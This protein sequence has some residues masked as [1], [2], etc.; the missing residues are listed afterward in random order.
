MPIAILAAKRAATRGH[1]VV[2]AT[3]VETTDDLLAE[4]AAA[5]GI[6]VERGPLADVLARF[7]HAL[8]SSPDDRIVVRLTG[9]NILPDGDLIAEVIEDF[10]VSDATYLST[11]DTKSGL[12][13]GVSVEVMRAGD[14]R[15]ANRLAS[16]EFEREHVTPWVRSNGK[17]AIFDRY[18]SLK[19]SEYRAT[20]DCFDDLMSMQRVFPKGRDP[21]HVPWREGVE[22]LPLGLYQPG[23]SVTRGDLVLGTAQLGMDYGINR[24]GSPKGSEAM[25][26][27]RQA[28][29]GGVQ[30][31]DTA[32]AYGDSE[33]VIGTIVKAGW[34]GRF[35]VVTK[36]DPL[37]S[38]KLDDDPKG[39]IAATRLSLMTSFHYLGLSRI[40]TVMLHRWRHW[41]AWGGVMAD[42]L[43]A[44]KTNGRIIK[45][46][47]SVQSPEELA[48]A[49][50]VPDI[51]HVQVPLNILDPRWDHLADRVDAARRNRGLVVHARS[52][53]LQGLLLSGNPDHWSH[54]HVVNRLPVVGWLRNLAEKYCGSAS[55]DDVL[56]LCLGW[57][58]SVPWVDGVV[59]GMDNLAQ[60]QTNLTIFSGPDLQPTAIREIEATRPILP[61]K[62]LDPAQWGNI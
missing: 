29:A 4:T 50:E 19:M 36:L 17:S 45:I 1:E 28:I 3:S 21:V 54:A 31:V 8:G 41:T 11:S 25:D 52:A 15:A 46:G 34:Q 38:W 59:V 43:K 20:I 42:V 2:L 6:L 22:R 35:R 44:E 7:C 18:S 37:E 47:A 12:P 49:L 9:D 24:A 51:E 27:L 57:V 30:W 56:A 32:R 53:L 14:L 23:T 62:T 10:E 60:L 16:T 61:A 26:M 40:D 58:R 39:V 33:A 55:V 5:Q 13:Y 48:E